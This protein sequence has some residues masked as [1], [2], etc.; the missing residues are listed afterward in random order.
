MDFQHRANFLCSSFLTVVVKVDGGPVLALPPHKREEVE[1][2]LNRGGG[3]EGPGDEE[4]ADWYNLA[5]LLGYEEEHIA[6]FQQEEHPIRALLSDWASKDCASVDA[7]CTALRK[8]NR[9]DIAQSLV[10]NP[11]T[12]PTATSAV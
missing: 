6:S 3:S 11:S 2:L 8:I 12:E 1:K 4:E 7:L 10:L 9:D 5:G